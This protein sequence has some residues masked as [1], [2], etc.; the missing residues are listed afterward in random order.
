MALRKVD[1]SSE[2][3]FFHPIT[4]SRS[5]VSLRRQG[6]LSHI[7]ARELVKEALKKA[8]RHPHK[9]GLHSLRSGGVTA[10]TN[11]GVPDRAFRRHGR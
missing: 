9:C 1:G 7:R 3:A 8:G 11:A 4:R 5:G 2:A 6:S 10:A